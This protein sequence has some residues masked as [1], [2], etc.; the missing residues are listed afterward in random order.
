MEAAQLQQRWNAL[1]GWTDNDPGLMGRYWHEI[2]TQY[3][4]KGRHYHTLQHLADMF[5]RWEEVPDS[6]DD[7]EVFSLAIFYH[8]LIYDPRRKDNEVKSAQLA[9]QRLEICGLSAERI[10]RC[11]YHILAT[12]THQ[13]QQDPDTRFLLDIDLGILGAE[14]ERYQAYAQQVRR[15]YAMYPGFLYRRGRRKVLQ[16]FLERDRIYQ[17]AHFFEEYELQA[18]KNLEQE[19]AQL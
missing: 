9:E 8:D 14:W 18:R 11:S 3:R 19:L 4:A 17:T 15:E 2:E 1:P 16:H 7:P 13:Q 10:A 5:E 6:V 12:A